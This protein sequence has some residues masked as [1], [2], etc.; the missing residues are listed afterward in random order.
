[1][2]SDDMNE[3]WHLEAHLDYRGFLIST[4]WDGFIVYNMGFITLIVREEGL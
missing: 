2:F 1:M 3:K 4:C